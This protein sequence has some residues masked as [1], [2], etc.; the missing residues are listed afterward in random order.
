MN[1]DVKPVNQEADRRLQ[2]VRLLTAISAVSR[3]M[4]QRIIALDAWLSE[5]SAKQNE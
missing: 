4:A 3:R 2:M 5:R 1:K